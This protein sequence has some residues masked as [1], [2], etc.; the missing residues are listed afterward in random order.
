MSVDA[1]WSEGHMLA[2]SPF[3]LLLEVIVEMVNL[4]PDETLR[5]KRRIT[6]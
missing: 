5:G 1:E 4:R 6:S 3:T 2:I